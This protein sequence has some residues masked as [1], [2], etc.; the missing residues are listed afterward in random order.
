MFHHMSGFFVDAFIPPKK[1]W[2]LQH[3][4]KQKNLPFTLIR[5]IL[6]P[7]TLK[8]QKKSPYNKV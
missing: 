2:L 8:K 6:E 1:T 5:P 7:K 4:K 3:D